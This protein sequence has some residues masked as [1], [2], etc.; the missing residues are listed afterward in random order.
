MGAV[1][2]GQEALYSWMREHRPELQRAAYGDRLLYQAL[3][4]CVG[5]GMVAYI[6]G[7]VLRSSITGEPLLFLGDLLYTL[8]YALWTGAV[9]VAL[10]EVVP[11]VKRR[12][13]REMLRTYERMERE[14]DADRD[15][16]D[17]DADPAG[18]AG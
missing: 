7:Y 18:D 10:L 14:A 6:G 2:G 16:R 13:V 12:Q 17:P 15:V 8:G 1:E 4:F 3:G 5:L 9:V 11:K